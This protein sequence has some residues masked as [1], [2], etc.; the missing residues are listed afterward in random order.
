M[1]LIMAY[2][3]L[4]SACVAAAAAALEPLCRALRVPTRWTWVAGLALMVAA[5][6]GALFFPVPQS[7]VRV[8]TLPAA[9]VPVVFNDSV[10]QAT[11]PTALWAHASTI[12]TIGW[13]GAS[14]LLLVGL[15][16]AAVKL[17]RERRS[18]GRSVVQGHD[19]LLTD[20]VGPAVTGIVSPVALIPRWVLELDEASQRLL[21]AHE[22]EHVRARDTAVLTTGALAAA[23]VPWNPLAWWMLRRLRLAVE[24][25]CDRRVLAR[26][27]GV[28]GYAELL[29]MTARMPS[30]HP[31]LLAASL[32][33]GDSDLERRIVAMTEGAQTSRPPVLR[34]MLLPTAITAGLVL[35]ACETPRPDPVGPSSPEAAQTTAE[36]LLVERLVDSSGLSS[37]QDLVA[38]VTT[39][40]ALTAEECEPKTIDGKTWV[41]ASCAALRELEVLNEL[42]RMQGEV[43]VE[44][45][46]RA[47]AS[48]SPR[49]SSESP[50]TY[51][52]EQILGAKERKQLAGA[53]E[54]EAVRRE[55]RLRLPMSELESREIEAAKTPKASS[56]VPLTR[57]P[58][59][60]EMAIQGA[61]REV[62]ELRV[63]DPPATVYV[64]RAPDNEPA[65]SEQPT[66]VVLSSAGRELAR[67]RSKAGEANALLERLAPHDIANIEVVKSSSICPDCPRITVTLKPGATFKP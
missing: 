43:I 5:T 57:P 31:R 37:L 63:P 39:L 38:R 17:W 46:R 23:L 22:M 26:G 53:V 47:E 60:T 65:L 29:L 52:L 9:T 55:A 21:V 4:L 56:I 58:E 40:T 42:H 3:L 28:R 16:V 27:A 13:L 34:R 20:G 8:D 1:I 30:A 2:A 41:L 36:N 66:V 48:A 14:L 19:V 35:I 59:P 64:R 51:S 11:A 50:A 45:K 18:A 24:V 62:R 54:R 67:W 6:A 15:A 7:E 12:A 25:D 44:P 61:P 10:T 49:G 32:G 33:E